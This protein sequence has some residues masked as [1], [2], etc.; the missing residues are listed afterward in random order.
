[1]SQ[2][3]EF[4]KTVPPF[5][6]LPEALQQEVAGELEV[7]Q[8]KKDVIA[9]H[10]STSVMEGVDI[11]VEGQYE[12]FFYDSEHNK[13]KIEVFNHGRIYGGISVLLNKERSIATIMAKKGTVV[14]KLKSSKFKKLCLEYE[15]FFNHFTVGFGRRMLDDEYAHFVRRGT[16]DEENFSASDQF[17]SARLETV[18]SRDI[19][20]CNANT[21]A[22]EAARL[23]SENKISCLFVTNHQNDIIGYVTDITLRDNV[24]AK[25]QS[26]EQP[27][28]DIM[29]NPIV[30]IDK[31]AF[32]YEAIFLMFRTKTRYLL[33]KEGQEYIGVVSRNKL[34]SDQAQSPFVFIQSVRLALTVEEL[35]KK[36][37]KVPMMVNQLL[38]RGVRSEMVNQVI[39]TV[40]DAITTKVIEGVIEEIGEPPARFIFMALGSEGRREQTLKTDQD[41]A[42]IYEDKA[43]EFREKTR[44]YFLH[45][46][47]LVSARLDYIGFSFCIG[48]LMAKNPKW[49]HSLSHWKRNYDQWINQ[50]IPESVMNFSTFFDCRHIYGDHQLIEELRDFIGEKMDDPSELFLYHLATNALRFDPPLTFF[51]NFR[52]FTK[53]DQKVFDIKKTMTPIVDLVRV[54][55]LKHKIFKTNTGERIK[56]LHEIGVFTASEYHELMQAYYYLMGMRLKKQSGKIINDGAEPNNYIDPKSLTIIEQ[57]TLKEIFK[58]IEKYQLRIK[59]AFT[60]TL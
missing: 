21:P 25:K 46:A 48:G 53:G 2:L 58:V 17:Y 42:I 23:M 54:Y 6:I 57:V 16:G 38:S 50:P 8:Y 13:R 22:F 43:N 11:I 24:I 1:M 32:I 30:Y 19:V 33:I 14:Y 27:V 41:N 5:D 55:A 45:F 40:S 56:A 15:D 29:D 18:S 10:Q 20:A 3:F 35:K 37:E 39:T 51:K 31:D 7:K 52:T 59:F 4:I 47:E 44:K 26:P 49:T 36:W 34:L 12:S 9:Y 28:G 60:K